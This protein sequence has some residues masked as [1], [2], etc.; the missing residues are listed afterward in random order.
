MNTNALRFGILRSLA[1][2]GLLLGAAIGGRAHAD[3]LALELDWL[4]PVVAA[5]LR[6]ASLAELRAT[7]AAD[8][9]AQ[10]A[11]RLAPAATL[12][13]DAATRLDLLAKAVAA[14]AVAPRGVGLTVPVTL[15]DA[16][17]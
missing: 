5:E 10:A 3:P 8:L 16:V 6:V 14:S 7:V 4:T 2:G 17:Q 13:L 1:L 11:A 15:V 12:A 9:S